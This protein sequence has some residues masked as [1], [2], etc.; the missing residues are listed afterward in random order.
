[1]CRTA[2]AIVLTVAAASLPVP[3]SSHKVVAATVVLPSAPGAGNPAEREPAAIDKAARSNTVLIP[4]KYSDAG[5][6]VPSAFRENHAKQPRLT[7]SPAL[8]QSAPGDPEP[9]GSHYT[10]ALWG[11]L[12]IIGTI[13]ARRRAGGA[14][15]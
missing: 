9:A 7:L 1:M 4:Q 6:I 5:Q 14:G 10:L 3:A 8:A 13:A 11:T 12:A 2:F 15:S